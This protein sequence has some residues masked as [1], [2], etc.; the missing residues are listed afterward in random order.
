MTGWATWHVRCA[1]C[2]HCWMAV[3]PTETMPP[4][5]CSTCHEM[6]GLAM[7]AGEPWLNRI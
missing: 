2:G 5:E 4:F 1:A 3:A 7:V 6:T